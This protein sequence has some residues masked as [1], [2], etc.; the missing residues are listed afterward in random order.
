MWP[1]LPP[2][3]RLVS[4]TA[5]E[6]QPRELVRKVQP[7]PPL[8]PRVPL[9]ELLPGFPFQGIHWWQRLRL[10]PLRLLQTLLQM[11]VHS[12][13]LLLQHSVPLLLLLL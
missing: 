7:Q 9:L 8:R 5:G 11:L 10:L 1:L 2:P 13:Q 3:Q 6:Q 4:H 12:V